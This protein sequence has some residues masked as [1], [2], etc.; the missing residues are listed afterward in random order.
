[1]RKTFELMDK[2]KHGGRGEKSRE[3]ADAIAFKRSNM[4]TRSKL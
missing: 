4:L 1:M 2:V 3:S